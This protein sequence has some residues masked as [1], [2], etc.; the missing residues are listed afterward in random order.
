MLVESM[1]GAQ[2]DKDVMERRS[3]NINPELV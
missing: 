2:R 3:I 1:D